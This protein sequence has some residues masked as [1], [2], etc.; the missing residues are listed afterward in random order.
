M[1]R[2]VF[3]SMLVLVTMLFAACAPKATPTAVPP[4]ATPKPAEPTATPKPVEKPPETK[5]PLAV[6]D[7]ATIVFSGWGDET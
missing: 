2:K 5:C 4:A 1:K 3:L 7:G 6:E